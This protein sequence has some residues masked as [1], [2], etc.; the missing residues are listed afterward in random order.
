M[1]EQLWYVERTEKEEYFRIRHDESFNILNKN[2]YLTLVKGK[3]QL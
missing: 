2:L 3:D 1:R